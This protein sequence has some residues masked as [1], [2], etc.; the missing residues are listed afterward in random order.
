MRPKVREGVP[1]GHSPGDYLVLQGRGLRPKDLDTRRAGRLEGVHIAFPADTP[2][3]PLCV[4]EHLGCSGRG[5]HD[6]RDT[7]L[8]VGGAW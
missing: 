3:L 2:T 5:D 1:A 6:Q 8:I 4:C 7:G